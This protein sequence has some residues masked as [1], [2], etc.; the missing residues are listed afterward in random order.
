MSFTTNDSD[1]SPFNFSIQGTGVAPAPEIVVSG[2]GMNITDGDITP[3]LTDH[4]DFG[5]ADVTGDMVTRTYTIANTGTANLTLGT[6]TV[7][8][9][10]AGDFTVTAQPISPVVASGSTTFQVTFDPST[11][12]LRIA[13]FSFANNDSDE[14]PFNIVMSGYGIGAQLYAN[15]VISELMYN[16][17]PGGMEFIE[18]RNIGAQPID[19]TGCIFTS[20]VDYSFP[21]GTV[22]NPGD[23]VVV[24]ETQFLNGSSLLNG[25]EEITLRRPGGEIIR[26]FTY[27]D[28]AP[29]PSAPD[30][31]GPSLVLIAPQTNPDHA[32]PF[33]WRASTAAGGNP[34]TSDG[35]S[36]NGDPTGDD[37]HNGWTNIVEYSLGPNPMPSPVI[38]GGLLQLT[39]PRNFLA[40]NALVS[41][42][43]ST[44][45]LTWVSGG[46][47][48]VTSTSA[49]YQAPAAM[50]NA[51]RAYA[52]VRVQ[53]AP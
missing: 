5:A 12:G 2:N 22:L 4:T 6:V 39:V 15:L 18:L 24:N 41:C 34:G 47:V 28:Q 29:W 7:G 52:R 9:A 44:D 51:A 32:N 43:F 37:D 25:G 17:L 20:G 45:L 13:T 36:F 30:G 27:G 10:N 46:L 23:S 33:N 8:G 50:L 11:T 31:S 40:D 3:S 21:T 42:E 49:T 14:N 19:I 16:P 1:E 53:Y 26:S 35:V 38:V 48:A